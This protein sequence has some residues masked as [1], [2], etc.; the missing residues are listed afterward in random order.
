MP[1]VAKLLWPSIAWMSLTLAPAS[2][3]VRAVVCL[4]ACTFDVPSR[5]SHTSLMLLV[6]RRFPRL[7]S[8]AAMLSVSLDDGE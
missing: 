8:R 2:S 6:L 4:S 1:V 3:M 7:R 5:F